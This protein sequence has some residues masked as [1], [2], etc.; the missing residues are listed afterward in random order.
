VAHGR[1]D[2]VLDTEP[3]QRADH[4]DRLCT[5]DFNGDGIGDILWQNSSGDVAVWFM[6][7]SQVLSTTD[8]GTVPTSTWSIVGSDMFGDILWVDASSNYS[9]WQVAAGR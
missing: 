6:N 7:G 5:G 3:R 8:L 2:G 9:I 4:L 1:H